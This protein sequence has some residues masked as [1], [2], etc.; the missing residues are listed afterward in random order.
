[1]QYNSI[2]F[3]KGLKVVLQ[4]HFLHSISDCVKGIP[5]A[6]AV[7]ATDF[8]EIRFNKRI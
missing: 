5:M 1:M 6:F 8:K 3:T 7:V 4:F 2:R